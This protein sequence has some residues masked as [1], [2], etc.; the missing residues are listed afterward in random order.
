MTY[1][2]AEA[3]LLALPRFAD[4]GAAA[5]NPGLDRMRALLAALGEPH[6]RYPSVHVAGTNGKGSTASMVAAIAQAAGRRVGLHTSPHLVTLRERMRVDGVPA[7]EDWVAD[8]VGRLGDALADV[9]PSF[10]EATV[11]LSFL[12]FAEA[13]V[14]LAVV[15][16]GLGGRLDAT[17]VLCPV[18]AAVT[19]VG[20]DHTDLLG[21][22][23]AE[24]AR[25]KAGIAK[26]GV[27]CLH[28]VEDTEAAAALETEARA[29]GATVEAVRETCRADPEAGGLR[30]VTPE[31]DYGVVEVGLSGAHQAWNAALAV[32]AAEVASE[33][34]RLGALDAEAVR[35]G[36]RNV[37]ALSG[38]RGRG[39]VWAADVRV[40]LDV[41][42]NPD[43]WQAAL[44]A[45]RVP[46]AG[47][48]WALVG[49][50][51]DKDADALAVLLAARHAR[52]FV[53]GFPGDRALSASDL[54]R[55]LILRG[56]EALPVESAAAALRAFERTAGPDDR[57][58]VTGSH[59][60][61]AE[62]LRQTP[63]NAEGRPF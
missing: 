11:A 32:R 46:E 43:G 59:L 61:V 22:T 10:F 47:R 3:T 63:G 26:A 35:S 45:V 34:A 57:M 51:A 41:A 15:E 31:A 1:A 52:T 24:I 2:E 14:D 29:R 37:A 56:V 17:N 55:R 19:H 30:L 33:R 8:A 25:E 20:L 38:L 7:S 27:P 44:D 18:V 5:Y 62:I 13:D 42:H 39:E 36:L 58:L 54:T 21:E 48:L 28:A 49:A 60:A 50:M 23:L 6:A 53:V 16:V 9:G 40:T 12:Y 4:A